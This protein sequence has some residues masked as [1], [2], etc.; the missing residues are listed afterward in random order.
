MPPSPLVSF[1]NT[2]TLTCRQIGVNRSPGPGFLWCPACFHAEINP[3]ARDSSQ[4][5]GPVDE[6][7]SEEVFLR[8]GGG[9]QPSLMPDSRP[10][11]VCS[12]KLQPQESRL[13]F[14]DRCGVY[15]CL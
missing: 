1:L 6:R 9:G 11:G 5:V 14:R 3:L 2:Q 15:C 7:V 4:L 13:K 10:V 8:I 12:I